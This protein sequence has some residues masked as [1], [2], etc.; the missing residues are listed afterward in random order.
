MFFIQ[1]FA[2][3]LQHG[4]NHSRVVSFEL[5]AGSSVNQPQIV[6]HSVGGELF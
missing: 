2:D 3:H 4:C 5:M 1:G 6:A